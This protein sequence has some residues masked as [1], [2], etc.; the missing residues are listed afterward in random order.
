MKRYVGS[1][2]RHRRCYL[3]YKHFDFIFNWLDKE[4]IHIQMTD[5]LHFGH[6]KDKK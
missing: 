2:R 4:K 3:A 1:Q 6:T 5:E